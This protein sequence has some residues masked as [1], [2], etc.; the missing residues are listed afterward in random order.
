M[1]SSCKITV[2]GLNLSSL[3]CALCREGIQVLQVER[4]G[5]TFTLCV[6]GYSARKTLA[7][8][9]DRGYNVTDIKYNGIVRWLNFAKLHPITVICAIICIACL[10]VCSTVCLRV[11][12]TGDLDESAVRQSLDGLGVGVGCGM[13]Q[14][15][16]DVLENAL[17]N[18]LG[19]MYVQVNKVGSVL[20]VKTVARRTPN[21]TV[22]MHKRRDIVATVSGTVTSVL[23]E[24]GTLC[25]KVG[26]NVK[27]GDL[28]IAGVRTYSDGATE[29]VYALGRVQITQSYSQSVTFDGTETQLV[30]TGKVQKVTNI[31]LFGKS[32]G[33]KCCFDEYVTQKQTA[34]LQ[35]LNLTVE[36]VTYYQTAW[37]VVS[38]A[39][40]ECLERL[41][42]SAYKLATDNCGFEVTNVTYSV[43]GNTVTATVT[44]VTEVN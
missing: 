42:R 26:D 7:I 1:Q 41:Q 2:C 33:T 3:L 15:D 29:N 44:G 31:V 8:L 22:D 6:H 40:D 36:N 25:V 14:I 17:C 21:V 37:Q 11:E 13:S 16:V 19:A 23:C 34:T 38:V 27:V 35:P 18:N 4:Q 28:L 39:L 24:Q 5:K 32:Y 10:A 30:Q 20:Y 12:V 43:V 9:R